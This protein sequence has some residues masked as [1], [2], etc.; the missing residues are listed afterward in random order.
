MEV[1]KINFLY[2]NVC[3][4]NISSYIV[5]A[6]VEN[7]IN[8]L[9]LTECKNI[10]VDYLIRKLRDEG[11]FFQV[12]RINKDSRIM[13]LHNIKEQ[14]NVI[15]ESKYYSVFNINNGDKKNLLFTLHLPSRYRQEK[16]DLNMYASQIIREFEQLEEERN[17]ENS[18]V[19]GDFNMN[20]F[21]SGMISALS[22]N[23]V[24]CLEIAKRR[25]RKVLQEERKFYYNPMWHLMGNA[26]NLSK[27]T[28]YY[29]TETK[30]YYWYT[31]DQVILRPDLIN[32]FDINKLKIIDVVNKKS[33]V[34]RNNIPD[35]K[36]ISDHLPIKFELK[37]EVMKSNG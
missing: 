2:W 24:M 22:F 37:M 1:F 19:V 15:K 6:C 5:D 9:I 33:L 32:K 8:I 17:T 28:F 20:P 31:Y 21:D 4:N 13:L 26:S 3:N 35:K 14:I 16:D 34:S 23:A 36:R 10:D 11:M 29:S 12:E 27:G 7:K 30:S 25:S 18:I